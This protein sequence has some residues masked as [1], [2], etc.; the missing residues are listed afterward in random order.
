MRYIFLF[1]CLSLF[2]KKQ[3]FDSSCGIDDLVFDTIVPVFT[4]NQAN[5]VC[6]NFLPN[7]INFKTNCTFLQ[8][9]LSKTVNCIIMINFKLFSKQINFKNKK[10]KFVL[11]TSFYD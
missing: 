11:A 4:G 6:E 3:S 10:Y 2:V 5:C 9:L 7:K 8:K 1:D